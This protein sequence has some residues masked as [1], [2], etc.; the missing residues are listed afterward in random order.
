M[1]VVV[2]REL[3][4]GQ[5]EYRRKVTKIQS[6]TKKDGDNEDN[7]ITRISKKVPVFVAFILL[8]RSAHRKVSIADVLFFR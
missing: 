4:E 1:S 6:K 7:E 3:M 5:K 8:C 2:C